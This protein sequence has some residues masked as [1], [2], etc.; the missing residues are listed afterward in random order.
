MDT[1]VN[2]KTLP[3]ININLNLKRKRKKTKE[4]SKEEESSSNKKKKI[5]IKN[6]LTYPQRPKNNLYDTFSKKIDSFLISRKIYTTSSE[7]KYKY[8]CQEIKSDANSIQIKDAKILKLENKILFFLLSNDILYLYQIKE[9]NNYELRKEIPLNQQDFAFSYSPSN[10]FFVTPSDKKPKKNQTQNNQNN[11]KVRTRMIVNICIVSCKERYLCQFDLKNLVFKKIKNII[12]KKNMAQ[13]LINND[14]KFKL[15]SNNKILSYNKNCAYIQ[16]LYNSPKFKNLKL[17][18]IESVSLL[19]DN[20]FSISTPDT[21]YVYETKNET[22][23]GDFKTLTTIKKAKLIKPENNLL[24]AYS[25][26]EIALYDLESLMFF[27][28]LDINYILDNESIRKVKQL[29]NNNIAILFSSS[30]AVYNMEKNAISYKCNYWNNNIYDNDFNG[31][32]MEINPNVVLVNNDEK[33]MYLFNCIK[34]DKIAY[35]NV[36][37]NSFYLCKKIKRY[38]F[39]YGVSQDKSI[40]EDKID[41][42]NHYVLIRDSQSSFILNSMIEE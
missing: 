7:N 41:K 1:E 39:K 37:D 11:A 10:I 17:K 9:H 27:Q 19:N 14:M 35:L 30:F 22:N 26:S 33:N 2:K 20:L 8:I 16:R 3:K 42:D 25:S 38:N 4:D 12:P 5:E 15:Y 29:N 36:N 34:G 28:K 24:L 6:Y 13:Y 21:V 31:L 18:N 32:L 23:I 40:E